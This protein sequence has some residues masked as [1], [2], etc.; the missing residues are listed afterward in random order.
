[1]DDLG[2]AKDAAMLL[3]L[4]SANP[5]KEKGVGSTDNVV[6]DKDS[7]KKADKISANLDPAEKGRYE[8]IFKIFKDMVFPE[9]EAKRASKDKEKSPVS[10]VTNNMGNAEAAE[11]PEKEGL[12]WKAILY[13]I[14]IAITTFISQFT[15]EFD[16]WVIKTLL[17]IKNWSPF[18]KLFGRVA[19]WVK[20]TKVFKSM[21]QF[22]DPVVDMFKSVAK[23]FEPVKTALQ[24]VGSAVA[25][26]VEPLVSFVRGIG[27]FVGALFGSGKVAEVVADV[28]KKGGLMAKLTKFGTTIGKTLLKFGRFLPVI[29]SLFSFGFAIEK[30]SKGDMVGGGLELLSGILNLIPSGVTQVASAIIDGYLLYRD[31]TGGGEQKEDGAEPE[32]QGILA[33]IGTWIWDFISAHAS[34]LPVIGGFY[35]AGEVFTNFKEG[36]WMAG[37]KALALL[38]VYFIGGGVVGGAFEAGLDFVAGLFTSDE[39]D[40]NGKEPEG[41]GILSTIGTSIWG[42]ITAHASKLPVIGGIYKAGEVYENFKSGNFLAGLKSLALLPVHFIGGSAV[43]GFFESGLDFIAGLLGAGE[44]GNVKGKSS[45]IVGGVFSWLGDLFGSISDI[46]TDAFDGMMDWISNIASLGKKAIYN[47]LPEWA[48]DAWTGLSGYDPEKEEREK[49]ARARARRDA[50]TAKKNS[51][52]RKV[53]D[54]AQ[55]DIDGDGS[56]SRDEFQNRRND[57]EKANVARNTKRAKEIVDRKTAGTATERDLEAK[58]MLRGTGWVTPEEYLAGVGNSAP[59]KPSAQDMYVDSDGNATR[60]DNKDH[61]FFFK[62]GGAIDRFFSTMGGGAV[63]LDDSALVKSLASTSRESLNQLIK[64]NEILMAIATNTAGGGGSTPNL[65]VD[66]NPMYN[67]LNA[68]SAY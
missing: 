29:G 34:K 40:E 21:V 32:G 43:G 37:L 68:G 67:D 10:Y 13:A 64:A 17:K 51:E 14:G 56:M 54:L 63:N 22:F 65:N 4:R 42:F 19:D 55:Y 28:G 38:P 46:F 16:Q 47:A 18:T 23:F 1:M 59:L 12:G 11:K 48:Q 44:D 27:N 52:A 62:P 49:A 50:E 5:D 7:G 15:S 39:T 61:K 58:I 31:L 36:N 3:A 35:K 60:L 57:R 30:F 33:S 9:A 8:N 66:S 2:V 26:G 20:N 24:G 6:I 45:G 53:K 41:G 25:K